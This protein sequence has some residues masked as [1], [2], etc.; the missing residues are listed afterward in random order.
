M[1]S[2]TVAVYRHAHKPRYILQSWCVHKVHQYVTTWGKLQ[3]LTEKEF[4]SHGLRLVLD[5]LA[6]FPSHDSDVGSEDFGTTKEAKKARRAL[7]ECWLV[8]VKLQ[9]EDVLELTP[10]MDIGKGRGIGSDHRYLVR[11]PTNAM[12]FFQTISAAFEHCC[13]LSS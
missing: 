6:Q 10:M 13:V 4:V 9:S 8:H 2:P 3:H 11:L 7:N 12:H 5:D 1:S